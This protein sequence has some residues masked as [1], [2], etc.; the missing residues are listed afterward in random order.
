MTAMKHQVRLT[1]APA[2]V[3]LAPTITNTSAMA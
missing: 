1:A 3:G 2:R